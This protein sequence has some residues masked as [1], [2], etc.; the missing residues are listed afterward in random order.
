MEAVPGREAPLGVSGQAQGSGLRA[1]QPADCDGV[2][3]LRL[4]CGGVALAATSEPRHGGRPPLDA[5]RG[6][7]LSGAAGQRVPRAH[8]SDLQFE[9]AAGAWRVLCDELAPPRWPV[10]RLDPRHAMARFKLESACRPPPSPRRR[11]AGRRARCRHRRRPAADGGAQCGRGLSNRRRIDAH[12]GGPGHRRGRGG[13]GG[14]RRLG[15][16]LDQAEGRAWLGPRLAGSRCEPHCLGSR[17]PPTPTAPTPAAGR[18]Q[19]FDWVGPLELTYLE[20]PPDPDDLVGHAHLQARL[21]TTPSHSTN[22]SCRRG[23][24]RRRWRSGRPVASH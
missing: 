18:P 22:P 9:H 6:A 2:D 21:A 24:W 12:V 1:L 20:Q 16:P 15:G 17:W 5:G 10:G 8:P 19:A 3:L 13:R 7:D 23:C 11:V 4:H 14:G